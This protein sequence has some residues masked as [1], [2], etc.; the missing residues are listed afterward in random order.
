M[1]LT[2][3]IQVVVAQVN[4]NQDWRK[5]AMTLQQRETLK[6]NEVIMQK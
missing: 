4:E 1:E 2:A 3:K 6:L 5:W